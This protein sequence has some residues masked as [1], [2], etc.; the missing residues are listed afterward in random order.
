MFP[1]RNTNAGKF[2]YKKHTRDKRP[3]DKEFAGKRGEKKRKEL[4]TSS[5][6]VKDIDAEISGLK[7]KHDQVTYFVVYLSYTSNLLI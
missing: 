3:K 1:D 6:S 4:L 2:Q 7:E 5:K